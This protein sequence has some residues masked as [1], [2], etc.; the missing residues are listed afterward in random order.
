MTTLTIASRD[1]RASVDALRA[2]G[3]TPAVFYGPKEAAT[4]VAVDT[5]AFMQVWERVGGSAIVDL[6]GVGEDKEVLIHDVAWHPTKNVP[7]HIDFYCIER[8]KMLMVSVPFTFVGE[9]PAEK[10]GGIVTKVMHELEVEVRPRDI[11]QTIEVD[12]SV[13]TDLDSSLTVAELVLPEG[14]TPTA[15]PTD[16]VLSVTEAKEEADEEERSIDDVAIT[17]EKQEAADAASSDEAAQ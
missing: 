8:G 5:R 6:T 12:M 17:G 11:P 1:P 13:L 15:E 14:V 7:V 2:Q 3:S 16:T 9:A 10:L 4:P